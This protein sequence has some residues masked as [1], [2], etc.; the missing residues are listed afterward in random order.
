MG[1]AIATAAGSRG[2]HVTLIHGAVDV[3]TPSVDA[4]QGVTT[5]AEMKSAVTMA[6]K[7]CDVCIMA[8]AVS[9]FAPVKREVQ[10]IKRKGETLSLELRA[11]EDILASL[12]NRKKG[13]IVVGFALETANGEANALKKAREKGCDYMALNAPG[14]KTGFSV[15]TNRIT[16]FR[17]Q[18]KLFTSALVSKED[19]AT[20]ILDAL[21]ADRRVKRFKR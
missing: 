3:P 8:A 18:T 13:Q 12:K 14:E 11:T 2:A 10:K 19:A 17:G 9:D 5:A 1:F 4:V 6:F 16:L 7:S 21:A 15:P 20:I